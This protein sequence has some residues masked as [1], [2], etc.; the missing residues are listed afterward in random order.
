MTHMILFLHGFLGSICPLEIPCQ[1]PQLPG[2][3]DTPIDP[4][5]TFA[6]YVNDILDTITEPTHLIGYSMGGRIAL[7]MAITRPDLFTHITIESAHPGGQGNESAIIQKLQSQTMSQFLQ[8]W[9]TQPLFCGIDVQDRI[10]KASIHNKEQLILALKCFSKKNQGNL[11]HQLGPV[12]HKLTYIC[13]ALD[14]KYV[15]IGRKLKEMY[16][17]ITLKIVENASHN[18]HSMV[19]SVEKLYG[20]GSADFCC[21]NSKG[22]SDIE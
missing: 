1:A 9:Y 21:H 17:D 2:H 6:Q 19:S 18:V 8:E 14:T 12:S 16:P 15:Q 5:L 22:T 4:S 13:G 10:Q 7:K 3:G 11:W 20:I